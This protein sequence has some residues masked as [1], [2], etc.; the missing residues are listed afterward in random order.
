MASTDSSNHRVSFSAPSNGEEASQKNVISDERARRKQ[1]N[2]TCKYD[3]KVMRVRLD[4]EE[5]MDEKLRELY[6][7][8]ANED[9]PIEIDIDDLLRLTGDDRQREVESLLRDAAQPSQEF[10]SELLTKILQL[11]KKSHSVS[12]PSPASSIDFQS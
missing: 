5:W 10:I 2:V 8:E 9:Y 11:Q 7:C 6:E 12:S 3:R 1:Q 4:I